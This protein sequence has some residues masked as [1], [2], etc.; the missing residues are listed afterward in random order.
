MKI[1]RL[2]QQA[3]GYKAFVPYPFPPKEEIPIDRELMNALSKATL[4]LGKLDGITQTLPQ[5]DFFIFMYVRKEAAFSSEIEGTRATMTDSIKAELETASDLP[6]DVNDI[7]HYIK[8][9]NYGLKR[10][11]KLPLSLRLVREVHKVLLIGGRTEHFAYPGEFRKTQNWID[12]ASPSSARYVPPP[13]SDMLQAMGDL[14]KFLHL[15]NDLPSLIKT[16]LVHAQFETIHPFSDGN[17]RTGRLLTT[18]YLC[19][20]K[21]L[22]RPVLYLSAYFKKHRE[23]YFERLHAYHSKD[24]VSEWLKFFLE[25]I[26]SVAESA[27]KTS[28]YIN[29]LRE[30]DIKKIRRVSRVPGSTLSVLEK[31]YG[32][33]IVD[34]NK[35]KE[36]SGL[37]RRNAYNL[38]DKLVKLNI[39]KQSDKKKKYGRTFR[40]HKYLRIFEEN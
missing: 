28:K 15:K 37:T 33:P 14:E 11:E 16:G 39:L 5:L 10:I 7:L 4:N 9:M 40:Y 22:E 30:E 6:K 29:K 21:I 19:Q 8:A 38:I 34:I 20:Q 3:G 2:I 25:G 12:G 1:G 32:L 26:A 17:G 35:V 13:A 36:W 18:F 23:V 27:T 31:L 24:E